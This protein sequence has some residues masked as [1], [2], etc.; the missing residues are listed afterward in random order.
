MKKKFVLYSL[1]FLLKLFLKPSKITVFGY[2]DL[3]ISKI[4]NPPKTSISNSETIMSIAYHV[5]GCSRCEKNRT[6]PQLLPLHTAPRTS[7]IMCFSIFYLKIRT[8][9][10][11][12]ANKIFSDFK[13][14]KKILLRGELQQSTMNRSWIMKL[15]H[16][17]IFRGLKS[18]LLW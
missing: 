12:K 3:G 2:R 10:H 9:V 17:T 15:I 7:L 11:I 1:N 18:I 4:K 13:F 6:A 8:H 14:A 5:Q 16:W